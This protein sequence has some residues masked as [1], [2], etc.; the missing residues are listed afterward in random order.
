LEKDFENLWIKRE[1]HLQN[2]NGFKKFNLIRG[3][4]HSDFTL[5]ASHSTWETEKDFINWT[6][7]ESFKKAHK[8]AG[9]NSDMYLGHPVF[10]GFNVII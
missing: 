8:N 7:S 3:K 5:Y 2:V 6:K 9:Q 4:S 10:E 1:S